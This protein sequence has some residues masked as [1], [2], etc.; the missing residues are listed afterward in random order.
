MK[1]KIVLLVVAAALIL[2]AYP[3]DAQQ[4]K[5]SCK[6]QAE[7]VKIDGGCKAHAAKSCGSKC[8][9]K[10]GQHK[11]NVKKSCGGGCRCKAQA[12]KS[13]GGKCG[14]KCGQHKG[15]VKKSCGGGCRCKAQ[16]AKS[17]GGKC[18][19]S[20]KVVIEINCCGENGVK[21]TINCG[22]KSGPQSHA[23]AWMRKAHVA[24]SCGG[25]CKCKANVA[26]SCGG[27]CK[28]KAN[29]A[30]SCGG[31]C[32]GRQAG[33]KQK[34]RILTAPRKGHGSQRML[35]L[36]P[37]LKKKGFNSK[38]KQAGSKK[39]GCGSCSGCST[40]K[41]DT[42]VSV[43]ELLLEYDLEKKKGCG[44]KRRQA[45]PQKKGCGGCGPKKA[46]I[47]DSL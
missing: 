29:A 47:H 8:G 9:G 18:G 46:E 14:G 12:A 38:C 37:A 22:C 41:I 15:N 6:G 40:K 23:G 43:E 31:A 42:E 20:C 36:T 27:A 2:M 3:G 26:K 19:G 11:G 34:M 17:C 5:G 16:A 28:C 7:I 1:L 45:A 39:G 33:L 25:A 4:C 13:C 24:K 44:G 10:C 32:K 30:K 35:I 21:V